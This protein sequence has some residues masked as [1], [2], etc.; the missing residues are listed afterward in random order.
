VLL[1]SGDVGLIGKGTRKWKSREWTAGVLMAS[2]PLHLRRGMLEIVG[3]AFFNLPEFL[4][5]TA[6]APRL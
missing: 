2:V 6:G 1:S 5:W 4:D 3:N